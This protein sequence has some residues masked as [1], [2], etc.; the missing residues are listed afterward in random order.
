MIRFVSSFLTFCAI[1]LVVIS[2]PLSAQQLPVPHQND[3][4]KG[5]TLYENGQYIHAVDV[6]KRFLSESKNE[7]QRKNAAYFLA[8]SQAANEP[9]LSELFFEHFIAQ[10]PETELSG[11]LFID[12]AHRSAYDGDLAGATHYYD[13]P[14]LEQTEFRL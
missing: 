4:F 13:R 9:Q 12:L 3:L 2:A 14:P 11:L 8:L 10:F 1:I 7:V 5:I 6:L